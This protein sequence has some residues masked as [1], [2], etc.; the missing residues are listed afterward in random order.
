MATKE[1]GAA[2]CAAWRPSA[3]LLWWTSLGEL[4]AI[5]AKLNTTGG[6]ILAMTDLQWS[7]GGGGGRWG[8]GDQAPA[9]ALKWY[10]GSAPT[11]E[12]GSQDV[13]LFR[14]A[15]LAA[16]KAAPAWGLVDSFLKSW[17]AVLC[18]EG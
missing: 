6:S 2:V 7:A 3:R 5:A 8:N 11:A 17:P 16:S 4:E 1:A 15:Q 9:G 14:G 13:L 12:S 18:R 10:T